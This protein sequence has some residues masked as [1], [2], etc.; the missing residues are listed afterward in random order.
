M[1]WYAR[2]IDTT[3][4]EIVP[5]SAGRK[6]FMLLNNGTTTVFLSG[7]RAN[8]TGQGTPLSPGA[9]LIFKDIDG[10]PVDEA[11]YGIVSAGTGDIRVFEGRPNK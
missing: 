9:A 6:T 8:I 10:D 2:P 7:D 11:I 1:P 5:Y 4:E 3:G